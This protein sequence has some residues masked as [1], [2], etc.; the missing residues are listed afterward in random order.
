MKHKLN[1]ILDLDQTLISSEEI[2]LLKNSHKKKM[3]L[4]NNKNLDDQYIVFERPGLQSFLDYLFENF[5]V[6]V[7]T[8][9]NKSYAIFI[10]NNF[11]LVKPNRKL[12][13]I[14][15]SYHC[16]ISIKSGKG[17][18]GLSLLWDDFKLK[19]YT[20]DNTIIIDDNL[21]VKEIQ[22]NNCYQIEPF[23]FFNEDSEN[24]N[25][26]EKLTVILDSLNP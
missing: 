4:F 6:S 23:Y 9:A 13:F 20:E 18:K 16:N 14:F 26:L 24:D 11:I 25:E 1:I 10:I 21:T 8:A 3:D 7:W 12:D 5:N 2:H 15:F 17:L 19:N 22:K